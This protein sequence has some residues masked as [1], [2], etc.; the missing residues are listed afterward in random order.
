MCI[1]LG[2]PTHYCIANLKDYHGFLRAVPFLVQPDD[3]LAFS[4][5]GV[6]CFNHDGVREDRPGRPRPD[7][8]EFFE[9]HQLPADKRVLE[10]RRILELD[11]DE[12]PDAFAVLW[13]AD[14]QLL[15]ELDDLLLNGTEYSELADHVMGYGPRGELFCFH[16][17]FC[18]GDLLVSTRV[19][20]AKVDEFCLLLG[21]TYEISDKEV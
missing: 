15:R 12:F 16:D 11:K 20:K 17:A 4:S 14:A 21:V 3:V 1:Y 6:R 7:I 18:G 10:E 19:P 2:T 8:R 5:Y 9:R 13:P